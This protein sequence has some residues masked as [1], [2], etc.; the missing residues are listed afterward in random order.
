MAFGCWRPLFAAAE[1]CPRISAE[2]LQ[3]A[4][5]LVMAGKVT[6]VQMH[7][8]SSNPMLARTD[9]MLDYARKRQGKS[10]AEGV[11]LAAIRKGAFRS[12]NRPTLEELKQLATVL[13]SRGVVQLLKG[14]KAIRVVR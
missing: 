3:L 10:P 5:N 9:Q 6:G 13:Q 8:R 12:G 14:G 2:T 4:A 7:E 11:G 1:H